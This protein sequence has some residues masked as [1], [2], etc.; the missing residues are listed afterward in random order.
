MDKRG[1]INWF[2]LYLFLPTVLVPPALGARP[3]AG[4]E[5]VVG[6]PQALLAQ[7]T[8]FVRFAHGRDIMAPA[9][10]RRLCLREIWEKISEKPNIS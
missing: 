6:R 9:A 4:L 10:E 1:G 8:V 3:D 5:V 7:V 2:P